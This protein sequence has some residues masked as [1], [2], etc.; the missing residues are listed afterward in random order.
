MMRGTS[1]VVERPEVLQELVD[2]AGPVP[3]RLRRWL[4]RS[5]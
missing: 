1:D 5:I 4:G 2:A 3:E